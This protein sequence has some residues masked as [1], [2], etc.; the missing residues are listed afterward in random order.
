MYGRDDHVTEMSREECW[1]MLRNTDLGR[2]AV[3]VGR[4]LDIFPVTY[5][6]DNSSLFFLTSPG[7]KLAALSINPWSVLEIDGH[8]DGEAWSVMAKGPAR[9]LSTV[10]ELDVADALQLT[11]WLPGEKRDIV[12]IDVDQVTGRRFVRA[13]RVPSGVGPSV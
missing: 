1:R 12:R 7:T 9:H 6:S 8:D 4:D 2:L 10:A 11:S 3:G 5:R 13:P